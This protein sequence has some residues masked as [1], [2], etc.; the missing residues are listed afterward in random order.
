MDAAV[1]LLALA[2]LATLPLWT[3]APG[4]PGTPG[5]SLLLALCLLAALGALHP[6]HGPGSL[7]LGAAVL[8]PAL[9]YFGPAATGWIAAGALLLRWLVLWAVSRLPAFERRRPAARPALAS[10][11]AVVLGILA[12]AAA[13]AAL[14]RS[15]SAPAGGPESLSFRSR[16]CR[17]L[18]GG[19]GSSPTPG[20][21]SAR[22]WAP[23]K[24]A[25][26]PGSARRR[27][28]WLGARPGG[29]GG[30]PTP[31]LV[32]GPAAPDRRF[33]AG[34]RGGPQRGPPPYRHGPRAGAPGGHPGR[35]PDHLPQSRSARN[36]G[37]DPGRV[38]P[39]APLLLVPVRAALGERA[40]PELVGGTRR[41]SEGGRA[42]AVRAAAHPA[43]DPAPQ[44]LEGDRARAGHERR[45]ARPAAFLV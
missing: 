1:P 29:G 20:R 16:G 21:E 42:R 8:P 36:R 12:A 18:S 6:P 43:R 35:A 37:A 45:A 9:V 19:A 34:A 11:G 3:E 7:S 39:G 27:C 41:A 32:D 38:P 31:G 17:S 26:R 24:L 2:L 23:G 30:G 5:S 13:L 40:G 15:G 22:A 33:T 25:A 4:R 28:G 44:R 10:A 14:G